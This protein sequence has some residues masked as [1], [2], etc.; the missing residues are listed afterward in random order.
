MTVTGIS[1]DVWKAGVTGV[2]LVWTLVGG[3]SVIFG[4]RRPGFSPA[5]ATS[6]MPQFTYLSVYYLSL[7]VKMMHLRSFRKL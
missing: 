6:F 2:N 3:R 7:I 1:A 4:A 5:F